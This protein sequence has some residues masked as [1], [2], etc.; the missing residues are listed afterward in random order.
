MMD[1]NSTFS[2]LE[3]LGTVV[4]CSWED[5]WHDLSSTEEA[6]KGLRPH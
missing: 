3:M 5:R 1:K 2:F 4:G 6:T